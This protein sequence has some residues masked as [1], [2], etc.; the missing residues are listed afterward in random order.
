MDRSC[1]IFNGRFA[2]VAPNQYAL[3]GQSY[4]P[5]GLNGQ[6]HGILSWCSSSAADDVKYLHEGFTSQIQPVIFS[7]TLFFRSSMLRMARSN[8]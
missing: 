5:V 3:R 1:G 8:E 2:S 7:A 6:F 4:S